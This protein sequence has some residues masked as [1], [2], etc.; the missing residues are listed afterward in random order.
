MAYSTNT[1]LGY[2]TL[3]FAKH[4]KCHKILIVDL[5]RQNRMPTHHERFDG[6]SKELRITKDFPTDDDCQWLTDDVDLVFV[7]ETPLNY[8]LFE[9]AR[10]KGVKTILQ[11]NYEFLD[12]YKQPKLPKP[13]V[14]ASPSYWHIEDTRSA[15]F[16]PVEYLPVPI[17]L[18]NIAPRNITQLKTIT[19]IGGRPAQHD[20]NGTI[21]FIQMALELSNFP[22]NPK[23]IQFEVFIQRPV[24]SSTE[25]LFHEIKPYIDEA[26]AMMGDQIK[27][28]FDI[29]NRMDMYEN[30]DLVV[31]PRKYGGLCLPLWEALAH[32]IPVLMPNID[33]NDK[34]LPRDW[35][36]DAEPCGYIETHSK[37]PMFKS[38]L[39]QMIFS[40][41]ILSA[42]IEKESKLARELAEKM[43]WEVQ[44]ENYYRLF[45][46]LL[47]QDEKNSTVY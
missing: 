10:D 15:N 11:Y 41:I 14:L 26:K 25:R 40:L 38:N 2:Q 29:E 35:L 17:D 30:A 31:L 36:I 20:R 27:F 46:S 16:A 34:V 44:R 33:P 45:Q 22:F 4:I 24:E 13:D 28:Y 8:S 19:H 42:T 12:Y 43:S 47:D 6:L 1:G 39:K 9:M 23:D 32:G 37:I 21:Q 7:C 18:K 5:S 3:D